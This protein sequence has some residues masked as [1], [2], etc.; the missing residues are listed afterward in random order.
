MIT[1]PRADFGLMLFWAFGV[2]VYTCGMIM[3]RKRDKGRR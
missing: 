3:Q 1:M 2:G